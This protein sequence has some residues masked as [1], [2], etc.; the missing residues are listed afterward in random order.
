M[1]TPAERNLRSVVVGF[2]VADFCRERWLIVVS[3]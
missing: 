3:R 1:P 2:V